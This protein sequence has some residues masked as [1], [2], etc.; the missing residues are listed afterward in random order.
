MSEFL[1]RMSDDDK[2][3][4]QDF[5]NH[6]IKKRM[7]LGQEIPEDYQDAVRDYKTRLK[8]GF[9]EHR[10][11][12]A[13]EHAQES[14][15]R[16]EE[17]KINQ[18]MKSQVEARRDEV[19]S[20]YKTEDIKVEGLKART[21]DART[22]ANR[23]EASDVANISNVRK[24]MQSAYNYNEKGATDTNQRAKSSYYNFRTGINRDNFNFYGETYK[25]MA[26]RRQE[27]IDAGYG[28]TDAINKMIQPS[29]T[30]LDN[31]LASIERNLKSGKESVLYN[32]KEAS[33][34]KQV[35]TMLANEAVREMNGY[36][37]QLDK[38][39][40]WMEEH[41]ELDPDWMKHDLSKVESAIYKMTGGITDMGTLMVQST[42]AGIDEALYYGT[43][44]AGM[45]AMYG[46]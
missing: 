4:S 16:Y 7:A 38:I 24:E 35:E 12:K 32:M 2:P 10:R 6:Y 22:R 18:K 45:G 14:K 5:I 25:E 28:E 21:E 30:N 3:G 8:E 1:K 40:K 20:D 42:K 41:P 31:R 23:F 33:L 15:K 46:G 19:K 26:Q 39:Q 17:F 11:E 36:N 34:R 27:Y 44:G 13:V 29:V 43:M 9:K 37:N